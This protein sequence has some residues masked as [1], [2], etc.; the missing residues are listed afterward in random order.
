MTTRKLRKN[1]LKIVKNTF[2]KEAEYDSDTDCYNISIKINQ[3][4]YM[5]KIQFPDD[6]TIVV[7][8]AMEVSNNNKEYSK[9]T[10]V[11]DGRILGALLNIMLWQKV[12]ACPGLA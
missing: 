9:F 3:N 4:V 2:T 12:Q 10:K 11:S 7:W 8:E 5:L 1:N 6:R